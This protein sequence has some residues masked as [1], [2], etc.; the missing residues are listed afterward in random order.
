MLGP[1]LKKT[2]TT[3]I[4]RLGKDALLFLLDSGGKQE[5]AVNYQ[6]HS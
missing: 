5:A 4:P 6:V 3:T 1:S 2:N